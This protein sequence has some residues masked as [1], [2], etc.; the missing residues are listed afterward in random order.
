MFPKNVWLRKAIRSQKNVYD[1]DI[2]ESSYILKKINVQLLYFTLKKTAWRANITKKHFCKT[3]WKI[4]KYLIQVSHNENSGKYLET[5]IIMTNC[6]RRKRTNRKKE[7]LKDSCAFSLLIVTCHC[8]VPASWP[9]ICINQS[10]QYT[11]YLKV[12]GKKKVSQDFAPVQILNWKQIAH[13][14]GR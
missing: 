9:K 11:G 5:Q 8:G 14:L 4:S 2:A 13:C 3:A 1:D 10:I 6:F 12:W 7:T